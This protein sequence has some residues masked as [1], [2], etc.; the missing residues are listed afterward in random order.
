L[1]E[2][3]VP[4]INVVSGRLISLAAASVLVVTACGGAATVTLTPESTTVP[5]E[6]GQSSAPTT[7]ATSPTVESTDPAPAAPAATASTDPKPSPAAARE[8]LPTVPA[9]TGA[10]QKT[11]EPAA[12]PL[13]S[14]AAMATEEPASTPAPTQ[15]NSTE[16]PSEAATISMGGAALGGSAETTLLARQ[17]LDDPP[18]D[19]VAWIAYETSLALGETLEHSHEFAFVYAKDSPH[20]LTHDVVRRQLE[21]GEGAAISAG[22]THIHELY[23]EATTFWEIILADPKTAVSNTPPGSRLVFVSDPLEG[24][25]SEVSATFV[26]VRV[27]PDGHTSVHIHPGPELIYQLSGNINYQNAIIGT[28]EMGTGGIEGIPPFV[29]VQKRNPFAEDGVFLSWFLVDPAQPFASPARF[30]TTVDRGVNVASAQAGAAISGVSSNFGRG[31]VDTAYGASQALD[32]NAATEW[33]SHGDGDNAWIEIDLDQETHVTSLGFWTRTMGISAQIFSFRVITDQGEV[34]GPFPLDDAST[35]H[36]FDTD[37]TAKRLRF[38][39]VESSGGNTGAVEI[40]VFG[41]PVP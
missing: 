34:Y 33:S 27:P 20:V 21:K 2:L 8:A 38:E 1:P 19:G 22:V 10:A 25:P 17:I 35:I 12:P 24:I 18:A 37:F 40:E 31:G 23:D 36:Y 9:T 14:P 4:W 7:A 30:E 6:K 32:G 41:E 39:A 13:P 11:R 29:A 26:L 15:G 28:I 16:Q 3:M 5:P